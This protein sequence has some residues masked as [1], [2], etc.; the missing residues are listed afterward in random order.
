MRLRSPL[1]LQNLTFFQQSTF[2]IMSH[3][4]KSTILPLFPPMDR[5]LVSALYIERRVIG[6]WT[7]FQRR[8]FFSF[9]S[10]RQPKF[11]NQMG[12]WKEKKKKPREK[13]EEY[14]RRDVPGWS[15]IQLP[16]PSGRAWHEWHTEGAFHL[17]ELAG[18]A[19]L[20]LKSAFSKVFCWKPSPSCSLFR[21]YSI[22]LDSFDK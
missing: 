14:S 1:Y 22:W 11:T 15:P 10:I 17:S 13:E 6:R 7:R 5:N 2:W 3:P 19:I 12:Q 18:P 4:N 21:I 8:V 9:F 20:T 16:T